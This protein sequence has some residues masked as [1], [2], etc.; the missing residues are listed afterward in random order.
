MKQ[1]RDALD[2]TKNR[3]Q[4]EW[5]KTLVFPRFSLP[6]SSQ[7]REQDTL[8][9]SPSL[10]PPPN[11][12]SEE[13]LAGPKLL[14][15]PS[16]PVPVVKASN[17]PK[18]TPSS[19]KLLTLPSWPLSAPKAAEPTP[20]DVKSIERGAQQAPQ[21]SEQQGDKQPVAPNASASR[22]K[23]RWRRVPELRQMNAVECGACCLAMI[24]N[25][26]GRATSVS[27][28][29]EDCGV[30]RD[31]L[32]ALTIAKAARQYGLRVRAVSLKK[33]DARFITF[34]AIVHWEFNHFMVVER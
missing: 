14:T 27:Q 3:D 13:M 24:L 34:P 11:Q 2:A 18:N 28:V 26:Y 4:R 31:G 7:E 16:F 10:L 25:Y 5:K 33:N 6:S 17:L 32:S 23:K 9:P 19:P 29:Q 8:S 1:A 15:L 21:Q 12:P 22:R 30:G 20:T